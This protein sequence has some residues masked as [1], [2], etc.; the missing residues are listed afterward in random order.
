MKWVYCRAFPAPYG[1]PIAV[2]RDE[3]KIVL[4]LGA[5]SR[6][7]I[8][9]YSSSGTQ[10]GHIL[11]QGGRLVASGWI[12][13][14]VLL[15]VDDRGKV[16]QFSPL[17]SVCNLEHHFSFG[18]HCED[19]GITE[20]VICSE[21]MVVRT[22]AGHIWI[23]GNLSR[24]QPQ[25][26]ADIAASGSAIHCMEVLRPPFSTSGSLEI[27][28]AVDNSVLLLDSGGPLPGAVNS[29]GPIV[30]LQ[31]SPC[32]KFVAGFAGEGAVCIWTINLSK[33]ISF[34]RL[35]ETM[36]DMNDVLGLDPSAMPWGPPDGF[37]WCG[38]EAV[39]STWSG[40]GG[41]LI[42]CDG[43]CKWWDFGEGPVV[44][45]TEIDGVRIIGSERHF[46]LR[47]VPEP[48]VRVTEIGST[49]PGALLVD[50]RDRFES[51]D[52]H[53]TVEILE[54]IRTEAL[55]DAVLDCMN[56]AAAELDLAK[57]EAIMRACSYGLAF[58]SLS[59]KKS[60]HHVEDFLRQACID[61]SQAQISIARKLR[62]V[63][64]VAVPSI[65]IPLTVRQLD[66]LGPSKLADILAGRHKYLHAI[67][68]CEVMGLAQENVLL[69]WSGEK[70]A[71]LAASATDDE[72]LETLD[73]KLRT[74]PSVNWANI[75]SRARELGKPKLAARLVERAISARDKVPLLISLG[76]KENALNI[77]LESGDADIIFRSVH[78]MW[79]SL[80][81]SKD[82]QRSSRVKE[83]EDKFWSI[84][85]KHPF[86]REILLVHLRILDGDRDF[87]MW[88]S[89][90]DKEAIASIYFAKALRF[91]V[92]GDRTKQVILQEFANAKEAYADFEKI[93]PRG[94]DKFE[95]AG[96]SSA[97]RLHELQSELEQST[98]RDGFLGLSVI[99]MLRRCI[100]LGL[101]EEAQRIARE[102]KVPQKHQM[103]LAVSEAA[104]SQDWIALQSMTARLDRRAP[105]DVEHIVR[106]ATANNAPTNVLASLIDQI[107][108]DNGV[109]RRVRLYAEVGMETEAR[110]LAE[111]SEFSG[112]PTRMF[113]G[114]ADIRDSLTN[115]MNRV[116]GSSE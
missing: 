105:I 83:Q 20:S 25:P 47:R 7:D 37:A 43:S 62:V 36:G 57:Q 8:H 2:C 82:R 50:A 48:L 113:S 6:P 1:G 15:T 55:A 17:G 4:Q 99:E 70:I 104:S 61:G 101:R 95:S 34:I 46:F 85:R 60:R 74:R 107:K 110:A 5:L 84:I 53:A 38:S 3:S 98:S 71:A 92:D 44:L 13:N 114:I 56:A 26:L 51:G 88:E 103:I 69:R 75:A 65:G 97:I 109:M 106:A 41:L 12:G 27:I 23:V 28:I 77:A 39:L 78:N 29:K 54:L 73:S 45:A 30:R 115:A 21:G 116:V 64:A 112:G 96:I 67:R 72:L 100:R 111:H 76:E 86:A 81:M 63:N 22:G 14:E 42:T 33:E 52:A 49:S 19:E 94:E 31:V 40:V 102:F 91:A 11:W 90:D 35:S 58:M 18:P 89:L 24:P 93:M 108:G 68:V 59:Q 66:S 10:M 87:K 80:H 79:D 32:G 9:I 16:Q